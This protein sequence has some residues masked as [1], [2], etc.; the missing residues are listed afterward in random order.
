MKV[1]PAIE[2]AYNGDVELYLIEGI[3][4]DKEDGIGL[5]Y[6][7]K[8]S[9]VRNEWLDD[10]GNIKKSQRKEFSAKF[11]EL[12]EERDKLIKFQPPVY[13]DWIVQ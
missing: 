9:E 4:G 8:S 11:D 7:F 1:I 2:N 3:R 5:I 12:R 10:E 13:T 6:I